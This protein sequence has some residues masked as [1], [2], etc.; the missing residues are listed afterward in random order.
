MSKVN[1]GKRNAAQEKE[2]LD[3]LVAAETA[4]DGRE[5]VEEGGKKY[6]V[7]SGIG[8][9]TVKTRVA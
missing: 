2:A 8:G 9:L 3:R 4:A 5:V 7:T 6:V 1:V